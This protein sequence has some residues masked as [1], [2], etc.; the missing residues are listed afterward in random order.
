MNSEEY[1]QW[2]LDS[3]PHGLS[4]RLLYV[5]F[6]IDYTARLALADQRT[7]WFFRNLLDLA[8]VALPFLRR[9]A[10]YEWSF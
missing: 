4:S 1:T 9:C 10:Y 6:V 2:G 5:T 7:E 8:I 3:A